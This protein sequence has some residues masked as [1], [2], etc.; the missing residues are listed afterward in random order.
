VIQSLRVIAA[1]DEPAMRYVYEKMLPAL[2]HQL[3]A[4]ASSGDELIETCEK[5]KPDLIIT[6]IRMPG[7]DGIDAAEQLW[8]RY[9]VPVL[10]VSAYRDYDLLQRAQADPIFGYLVKPV[11]EVD[12]EAAIRVA[13]ARFHSFQQSLDEVQQLRQ[14][15]NDRKL[16]ERAKGVIMARTKASEDDALRKLQTLAAERSKDLAEIAKAVVDGDEIMA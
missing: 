10:L 15:L 5:Q 11:E 7:R 14:T 8:L 13:V 3:I 4:V 1:D 16:I 2:G 12:L 6:D 9:N